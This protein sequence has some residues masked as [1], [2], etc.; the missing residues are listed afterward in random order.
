MSNSKS[1]EG[2]LRKLEKEL[3]NGM[4]SIIRDLIGYYERGDVGGFANE[5]ETL[6]FA[7]DD[8]GF[9]RKCEGKEDAIAEFEP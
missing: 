6:I 7:V 1:M 8:Y 5:V 2:E 9:E 3:P 4:G